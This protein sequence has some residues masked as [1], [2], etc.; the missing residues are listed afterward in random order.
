M[1]VARAGALA[2]LCAGLVPALAQGL[3]G[4]HA[5]HPQRPQPQQ[6][7]LQGLEVWPVDWFSD[8]PA[9]DLSGTWIF[10]AAQS[11]PMLPDWS[12]Q[13]VRY[14]I[15]QESARII[16]EFRVGEAGVNTQV[17]RWDGTIQR[18][19]RGDRQV[20]EAAR[21]SD[22]GRTLEVAGRHWSPLAPDERV[23]Y[24]FEYSRRGDLLTFVQENDAGRTRWAFVRERGQDRAGAPSGGPARENES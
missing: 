12:E 18:F 20:Q 6:G 16:L 15:R 2:L 13:E 7:Q 3:V 11:D 21:W 19:E 1:S 14:E 5:P 17:Y 10:D 8:L 9:L 23:H 4:R 24:R 22:A